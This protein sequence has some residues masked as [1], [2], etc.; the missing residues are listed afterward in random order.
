MNRMQQPLTLCRWSLLALI[1]LQLVWF[2]WLHPP[3]HFSMAAALALTA[4]PLIILL[5]FVW[6]LQP[7]PL[8]VA[9]LV[10]LIYFS[11]G[12]MEAWANPGVRAPALVQVALVLVY[13][14]ALATIRRRR[15]P[16]ASGD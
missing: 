2:G 9:G 15:R 6:R 1:A 8:V 13:F 14:T 3:Q 11:A 5:P 4:G 10:L 16:G 12:V 7:R